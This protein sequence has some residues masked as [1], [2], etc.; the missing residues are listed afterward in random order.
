MPVADSQSK[1]RGSEQSRREKSFEKANKTKFKGKKKEDIFIKVYDVR[2]TIFFNQT[3]H[4][5]NQSMRGNNYVMVMMEISSN[6]ILVE[7][8]K[9]RRNDKMKRAY[10]HIFIRDHYNMKLE[11]VPPRCHC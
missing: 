7:P 10:E 6:A 11:L 2:E 4:F 3:S 9:S 1:A 8:T 5:L